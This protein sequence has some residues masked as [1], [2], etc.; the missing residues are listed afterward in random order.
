[1]SARRRIKPAAPEPLPLC[2]NQAE[3]TPAPE[4]YLP[5]WDWVAGMHRTH[6][7]R[8]CSGCGRWAIWYPR[9]AGML[10]CCWYCGERN[11]DPADFAE[12]EELECAECVRRFE[13][14]RRQEQAGALAWRWEHVT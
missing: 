1:M 12:D 11:L 5:W 8:E 14:Q 9:P 7:Q 13:E 6:E 3:H 2:P 4:G 10:A